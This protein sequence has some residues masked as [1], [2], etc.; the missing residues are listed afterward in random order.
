MQFSWT[1]V[2]PLLV[3]RFREAS[4]PWAQTAINSVREAHKNWEFVLAAMVSS[5]IT[6]DI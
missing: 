2:M 4:P 6:V 5:L 3:V 1:F